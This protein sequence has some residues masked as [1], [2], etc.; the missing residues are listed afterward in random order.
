MTKRHIIAGVLS[1]TLLASAL[2]GLALGQDEDTFA[3]EGFTWRLDSYLVD[4]VMTAVPDEVEVTLLLDGGDAGGSGGCNSYFGS[5]E[6]D[7]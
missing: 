5:Y 7:G 2:P 6:I 1:A 3:A 4:G